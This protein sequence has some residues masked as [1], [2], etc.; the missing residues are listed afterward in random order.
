MEP[1]AVLHRGPAKVRRLCEAVTRSKRATGGSTG[2][3]H[4]VRGLAVLV[5][6]RDRNGVDERVAVARR[7]TRRV[8]LAAPYL[9]E[10]ILVHGPR[11]PPN[12]GRHAA[13]VDGV[14]RSKDLDGAALVVVDVIRD[15]VQATARRS[16]PA[17]RH[18][19]EQRRVHVVDSLR[20]RTGHDVEAPRGDKPALVHLEGF[21]AV[22]VE[23]I[24]SSRGVAGAVLAAGNDR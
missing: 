21:V 2:C 22:A 14:G 19:A 4:G 15:E 3:L 6:D 8:A 11:G 24:A 7:R 20:H 1:V 17:S 23:V 5:R 13:D 12:G 18:I 10:A 9:E 16:S